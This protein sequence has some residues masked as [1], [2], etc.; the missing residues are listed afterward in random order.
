LEASFS[1]RK[2]DNQRMIDLLSATDEKQNGNFAKLNDSP[3]PVPAPT[4]ASVQMAAPQRARME[5][6]YRRRHPT[7]VLPEVP[8][9]NL[10]QPGQAWGLGYQV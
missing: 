4:D 5:E 2:R 1:G 3:D 9:H 7:A 8:E 10:R 6:E